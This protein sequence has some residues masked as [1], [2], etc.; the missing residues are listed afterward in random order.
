MM[1]I[2]RRCS[3]SVVVP[4][5]ISWSIV[6]SLPISSF[7]SVVCS[8]ILRP[9]IPAILSTA[10]S[11][12]VSTMVSVHVSSH[13]PTLCSMLI[14][15]VIVSVLWPTSIVPVLLSG[16]FISVSIVPSIVSASIV[17][18]HRFIPK[19]HLVYVPAFDFQSPAHFVVHNYLSIL[20]LFQKLQ[21]G[22]LQVHKVAHL[23]SSTQAIVVLFA[24]S[25][26][27]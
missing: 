7:V 13:V 4:R 22:S 17:H 23:A 2:R 6:I 19:V 20:Q 12:V 3:P 18:P 15:V 16:S 5:L 8:S 10:L 9:V 21:R 27:E 11:V 26:P 25:I 24:Q 1:A 14:S